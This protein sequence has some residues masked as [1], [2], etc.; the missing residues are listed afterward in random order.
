MK[1]NGGVRRV[2]SVLAGIELLAGMALADTVVLTSGETVEGKITADD[3]SEI[4]I[5]VGN[6]KKT[7]FHTRTIPKSDIQSLHKDPAEQKPPVPL[8]VPPA[9]PTPAAA[10]VAPPVPVPV[11]NATAV[12]RRRYA[13]ACF[14]GVGA[15]QDYGAALTWFR[16]AAAAGNTRAMTDVGCLYELGLGVNPDPVRGTQFLQQAQQAGD[17]VAAYNLG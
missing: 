11:A 8:A 13:E 1:V 5:E 14:Y 16:S 9:P 6:A 3:G 12:E 15:P 10:P 2:L 4:A 17:G 7:I